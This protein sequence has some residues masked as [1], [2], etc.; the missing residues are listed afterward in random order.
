MPEA[1]V[2]DVAIDAARMAIGTLTA[3]PVP[4]PRRIDRRVAAAA[5]LV[6]P[7]A[8]VL[9]GLAAAGV[10]RIA[11]VAGA[12][13]L[14]AAALGIGSVALTTRGLHLDGLADTADGLAAS[15]DR[16]RALD[17]MRRGN[18]GPAGAATVVLVLIVQVTALASALADLGWL[19]VAVAVV[20]GRLALPLGCLRGVPAARRE[21]LGATVAGVVPRAAAA[22]PLIA[23]AAAAF[24][25]AGTRGI[26]A[27]AVGVLAAAVLL[28]RSVQRFGGITGDVLGACVEVATAGALVVLSLHG[29][30]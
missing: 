23:V 30:A 5:M 17:V 22:A 20:A 16:Q 4:A 12:P 6:A 29:I 18:T 19:A 28:A 3:L 2:I 9:P 13:P 10:C 27:V 21:G 8:A 7:L 26:V 15:Y 24:A 25:V 11:D 1:R 14:V